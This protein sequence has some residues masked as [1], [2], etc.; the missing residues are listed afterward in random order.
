MQSGV[1]LVLQNING[2]TVS[3]KVSK[4]TQVENDCTMFEFHRFKK[5]NQ[6]T[7][8]KSDNKTLYKIP[9]GLGSPWWLVLR[10]ELVFTVDSG[11][12]SVLRAVAGLLVNKGR[13]A[14]G[15]PL[16]WSLH[17]RGPLQV[18]F[19]C[20]RNWLLFVPTLL[21]GCNTFLDA[22]TLATARDGIVAG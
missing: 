1:D 10:W 22:V 21:L 12:V 9:S 4:Q 19:S 13:W 18:T 15:S 2:G 16:R 3:G 11:R 5:K 6:L 17:Y 20:L 8:H 14:P 7:C